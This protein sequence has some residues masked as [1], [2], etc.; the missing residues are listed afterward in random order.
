MT[1]P[2]QLLL[3]LQLL[4]LLEVAASTSHDTQAAP[5]NV[6]DKES[7][8]RQAKAVSECLEIACCH[9]T[10]ALISDEFWLKGNM[11]SGFHLFSYFWEADAGSGFTVTAN[12]YCE[13]EEDRDTNSR[14]NG[15]SLLSAGIEGES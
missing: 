4:L 12:A 3:R 6:T 8:Q 1:S 15:I 7:E 10:Q 11:T 9:R 13:F 5:Q 2:W 14:D